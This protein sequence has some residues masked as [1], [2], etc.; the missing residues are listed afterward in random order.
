MRRLFPIGVV[1]S[2]I[3]ALCCVGVLTPLLVAGLVALGLG[4]LTPN[5]DLVLLPALAIF[6]VLTFL[7]WRA[8]RTRPSVRQGIDG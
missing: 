2:V 7:G 4:T 5:L 3:A 8:R 1:G 6:L